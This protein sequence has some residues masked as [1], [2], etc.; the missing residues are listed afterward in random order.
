MT[1]L[2]A[3]SLLLCSL[4]TILAVA[5]LWL[6]RV[7]PEVSNDL[8]D[9]IDS[10]LPQTQCAQC[11]Y[12]G[13]RPYAKSISQGESIDLCIPGG[14]QVQAQLSALMQTIPLTQI[15]S[16]KEELAFIQEENCIG[17]GLCLPACP[18]DA[19]IGAKDYLHTVVA[20]ECTG[21]E[22]C[23]AACPVDCI[24]MQENTQIISHNREFRDNPESEQ[25]CI[26]CAQCD[27]ECP[28][29]ISPLLFHKLVS[30]GN[31]DALEQSDLFD[32]VEC[33]I[34]DL[35]CPSNI[36]LTNQFK[37]AKDQVVHN[38]TEKDNKTQL[39]VR[40]ERHSERLAARKSTDDQARSKRLNDRRPWL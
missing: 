35:N 30:K 25:A 7:F 8:I 16:P 24:V 1:A 34:C 26:N 9:E 40:Y 29:N 13:C 14:P 4:L 23:V 12:P 10:I 6:R 20:G 37:F 11:G 32:C 5:S 22:L 39:L 28:V 19:I 3:P 15:P 33:G 2:L 31:Y 21:C 18:V 36:G 27:D 17:C 38:K